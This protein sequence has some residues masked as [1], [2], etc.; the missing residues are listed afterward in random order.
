MGEIKVQF[1]GIKDIPNKKDDEILRG[2]KVKWLASG[3]GYESDESLSFHDYN[4]VFINYTHK[5]PYPTEPT[6]FLEYISGG[7]IAVIFLGPSDNY[8]WMEEPFLDISISKGETTIPNPKHWLKEIL[9]NYHFTWFCM[10]EPGDILLYKQIIKHFDSL[11]ENRSPTVR[12]FEVAGTTISG[13]CVSAIIHYGSGK[14]ILLPI[15]ENPINMSVDLI[16]D[17]L[18]GI[19][20]NYFKKDETLEIKP[21]SIEKWNLQPELKM[22]GHMDALDNQNIEIKEMDHE[23]KIF[24][25]YETT[26]GLSFAKHLKVSLKKLKMPSF[27]AAEDLKAGDTHEDVI[28]EKEIKECKYFVVVITISALESEEVK[29]EIRMAGKYSKKIIPCKHKKIE[30]GLLSKLPIII[31]S[32]LQQIDFEDREEL[33]NCVISEIHKI[34]NPEAIEPESDYHGERWVETR[35]IRMKHSVKLKDDFFKSWLSKIGEYNDEYCKIDAQYSKEIDIMVPLKPKEPDNLQFYNEATSHMKN[36]EQ[37]LKDWENQKQ[38]TLKLNEELATI[39][40][41]IR[42]LVKKEIDLHYWCPRYSGD[43]PDEYLCPNTFIGAIYEEVENRIKRDK[44]QFIGSGKIE[45]T[46]HGD[47]KI[48]Y[49]KWLDRTLARSPKQEHMEKAQQLFSQFI[50]DDRYK[51]RIKVFLAKQ[52]ETYDK[53]LEKVKQEIGEIIKSI[54]LGNII[55]GKCQ[56]CP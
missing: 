12:I 29:K 1:I 51:E 55:K 50:E 2:R 9:K 8:P 27:V 43:E 13:K 49:F 18:D 24:I 32:K 19:K 10:I 25:C 35:R 38:I 42:V 54:E 33:A 3:D 48:Y 11:A 28:R 40:E 56:Y 23:K 16:R 20:N 45:P 39:F 22:K 53:A 46:I 30:R 5:I 21:Q 36:Y 14:L 52:K 15:P 4:I 6:G 31:E 17:L 34:E 7:G 26:T 44:K 47:K 41:E 37:L